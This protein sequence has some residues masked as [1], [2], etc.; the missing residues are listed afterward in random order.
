LL[1]PILE[2]HGI[3]Q[4]QSGAVQVR[5]RRFYALDGFGAPIQARNFH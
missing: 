2:I 4:N 3:A 1:N 5:G